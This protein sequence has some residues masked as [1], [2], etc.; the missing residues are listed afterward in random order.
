MSAGL[1]HLPTKD[2]QARYVGPDGQRYAHTFERKTDASY[3]RTAELRLIEL[4][5]PAPV[6]RAE[7][8][9]Q[10]VNEWAAADIDRRASRSQKA[11]QAH[12]R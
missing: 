8:K 10:T 3:W 6:G 5:I 9:A 7:P 12:H 1:R 11:H 4:D 2:W